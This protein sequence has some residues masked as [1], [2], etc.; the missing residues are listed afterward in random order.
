MSSSFKV[1]RSVNFSG[2]K[3]LAKAF[4]T[5]DKSVRVGVLGSTG[6]NADENGTTN[7]TIGMVMELGNPGNRMY[8]TERGNPAPIPARSWLRMPL[9]HQAKKIEQDV[10]KGKKKIGEQIKAGNV[11]AFLER[12]GIACVAQIQEA[13][14]TRGF[15]QWAPNSQ[16][17]IKGKK[18][19]SPLIDTGELRKSV[20]Y[21]VGKK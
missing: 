19:D 7:A 5:R 10:V 4:D 6:G 1:K 21:K 11:D 12:V 8:N 15:G 20:S 17:T 3:G 14:A 9:M 2:L 18:S 13:F 16:V